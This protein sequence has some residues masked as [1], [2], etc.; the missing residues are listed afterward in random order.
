MVESLSEALWNEK[1]RICVE[2][3]KKW[4][5]IMVDIAERVSEGRLKRDILAEEVCLCMA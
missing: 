3:M 4:R 1:V 5:L 2:D